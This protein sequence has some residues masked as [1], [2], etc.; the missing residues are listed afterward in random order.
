NAVG[1]QASID[2]GPRTSVELGGGYDW[3]DFTQPSAFFGYRKA[4]GS[5]GL[6]FEVTPTLKSTLSYVYDNVPQIDERPEAQGHA[7][8]VQVGLVGEILPLLHGSASVGY[9]AQDSPNAGPGGQQYRGVTAS[10]SLTR[11]LGREAAVTVLVNRATPLSN[12]DQNAF[13]VTTSVA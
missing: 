10:A 4:M 8:T 9:R 2:V 3:V 7:H 1:A 12:F 11:D 5:V 6:G 13:Y